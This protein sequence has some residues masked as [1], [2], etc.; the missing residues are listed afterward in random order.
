MGL[1]EMGREGNGKIRVL[2]I[3]LLGKAS[4]INCVFPLTFTEHWSVLR[5]SQ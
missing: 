2:V 3:H 5:D 4:L 1:G